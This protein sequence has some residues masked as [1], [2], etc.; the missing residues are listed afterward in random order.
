MKPPNIEK[1]TKPQNPCSGE[2]W[3]WEVDTSK[4]PGSVPSLSAGGKCFEVKKAGEAV[5]QQGSPERIPEVRPE[6]RG[7]VT[8]PVPRRD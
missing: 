7:F 5:P 3:V 2:V 4:R 1:G 8:R 6:A